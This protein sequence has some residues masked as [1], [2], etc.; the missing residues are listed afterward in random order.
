MRWIL[1]LIAVGLWAQQPLPSPTNGAGGSGGGGDTIT[2]PNGTIT[3]GGT[4]TNTTLDVIPGVINAQAAT[5]QALAS[6]FATG[7]QISVASGTFT[8]T[9][10]ASGTQPANGQFVNIVNY[11]TGV[12]TVARSGQNIN[13]ATTSILI[14][15][16][17]NLAANG[18]HVVSDGT[19]YFANQIGGQTISTFGTTNYFMGLQNGGAQLSSGVE[20]TCFGYNCFTS[21]SGS[22]TSNNTGFG[23]HALEAQTGGGNNT[24][25]GDDAGRSIVGGL[26]NTCIG[27]D[28]CE[29][30]A[31]IQNETA[32][33]E[34]SCDQTTANNDTCIG[35]HSGLNNA[36]NSD[37]TLVGN[38]SDA[39]PTTGLTFGSCIGSGC[40]VT[41]SNTVV[42][43]RAQEQA[44]AS[45]YVSQGT[46]FT[47][48]GCSNGTTVGGATAGKFTLGANTCNVVITFN[49]A[50]GLTAPNEWSCRANDRTT[51]AG[52]T[53]LYFSAL[54][55]TTATLT[56]PA[57]A[58]T[59]DVIDFH[60]IGF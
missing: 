19:N 21:L 29:V 9:L 54:S 39:N 58:G 56:V 27:K 30:G 51:A 17:T 23:A 41:A 43:G 20:N 15:R 7:K 36:S 60:C 1:G 33:G 25:F 5:Y 34:G 55:A 12:V 2:S 32:V 18:L 22:T 49:G 46:K 13:G 28:A 4:S 57:T 6:D 50:T 3:V 35:F 40:S 37:M 8:I 59:T 45:G 26:H 44:R 47:A 31:S 14:P 53:G 24:A 10:V 38:L 16:G 52:N 11:G 48:S 42:L